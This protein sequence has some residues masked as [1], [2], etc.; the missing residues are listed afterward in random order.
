M[1]RINRAWSP[2]IRF[3]TGRPD[4]PDDKDGTED[5]FQSAPPRRESP[6]SHQN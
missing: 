5:W 1:Q 4:D 6:N 3:W 2:A